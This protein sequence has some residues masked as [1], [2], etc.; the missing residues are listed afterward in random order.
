[1]EENTS[2]STG[3]SVALRDLRPDHR[4]VL[5]FGTLV[6]LVLG[7]FA[8]TFYL[9]RT[10]CADSAFFSWLM[11]HEKLPVSVLGRY[12][13]WLTQL[14]PV[15]LIRIGASLE[16][17]LRAYSL[18]F[19]VFHAFIFWILAF[20]LKDRRATYALPIVLTVGFHYMFYFGISELY[21]G[22]SLTVLLWSI[23]GRVVAAEARRSYLRWFALAFALNVW[24]SFYHQLLVLPLVFILGYEFLGVARK[25]RIRLVIMGGA[26]VLWYLIRIKAMATSTYEQSRMPTVADLLHYSTQWTQLDSATYLFAV[27]TKFHGLLVLMAAG[28]VI[29]IFQRAWLRTLWTIV[30]TAL[31]MILVLIVDRDGRAIMIYENYYPVL[32]LVWV[33]HFISLATAEG[34]W[35]MRLRT[36]LFI[37][38]CTLGVMQIQRAHFRISEKVAYLQRMTAFWETQGRPKILVKEDN[39]PWNYGVGLWP[40]GFESTL[41]SAVKGPQ[42]AATVFVTGDAA[43]LDTMSTRREQ[44]L[45]PSWEPLWFGIPS[46]NQR[47]FDLPTD[48]GYFWVN[49]SDTTF[50]LNRLE[51]RA[52]TQPFHM[53]PDRYTVVPILIHNPTTQR[54]PSCAADGK[55]VRM[56]YRL[57]HKDG[58]EYAHGS[59]TTA[60]ETD[61]PPGM[62]YHQGLVIERPKDHGTYWVVADLLVNG[63]PFGKY[64]TFDLVVDRRPF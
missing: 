24:V 6:L 14:L 47:Y 52:P 42:Y 37:G 18:S 16:L 49:T 10:A 7:G 17:V 57:F 40:L 22:L 23:M 31:F 20:K 59:E 55:P 4:V 15:A 2:N 56:G 48:T 34:R 63:L 26:M 32:G 21:Q 27:W 35:A 41:S 58:T 44:F 25:G 3:A 38:V 53:A 9:E 64:T 43:L 13:S 5:V 30:F 1:M 62:T 61:I 12:G 45:G 39:Y 19:V 33:V 54:M 11:I 36:A 8:W 51:L 50:D 29:G 28:V 60:L 46:L